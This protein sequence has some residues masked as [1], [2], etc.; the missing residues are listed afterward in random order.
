MVDYEQLILNQLSLYNLKSFKGHNNERNKTVE[1]FMNS[2]YSE[3]INKE[4]AIDLLRFYGKSYGLAISNKEARNLYDKVSQRTYSSRYASKLAKNIKPDD[5]HIPLMEGVGGGYDGYYFYGYTVYAYCRQ[6]IK[7]KTK[8]TKKEYETKLIDRKLPRGKN[9][10]KVTSEPFYNSS[11]NEG[12]WSDELLTT[13][14]VLAYIATNILYDESGKYDEINIAGFTAIGS[15]SFDVKK[16]SN[17]EVLAAKY[18]KT[19]KG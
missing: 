2:A 18:N 12:F 9:V 7:Y 8:K 6:S 11:W 17:C 16:G 4:N 14:Q 5:A 3:G 19:L 15:S 13:N 10:I 1:Y